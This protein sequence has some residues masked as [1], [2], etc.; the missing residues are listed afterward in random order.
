[1]AARYG[2][3]E[4]SVRRHRDGHLPG[5]L[6]KAA[7]AG[8]VAAAGTLL[9]QVTELKDRALGIRLGEFWFSREYLCVF[10]DTADQLFS[11]EQVQAALSADVAPLFAPGGP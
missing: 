4:K 9:D 6:V 7:A 2:L 11:Y 5:A 3:N 8:E 1:V 10:R